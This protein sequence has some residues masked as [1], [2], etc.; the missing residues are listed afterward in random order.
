MRSKILVVYSTTNPHKSDEVEEAS[1]SISL[2]LPDGSSALIGDAFNFDIRDGRP[3]EPLERDL[4]EMVRHK[5]VSAYKNLL[6][7]CIAEHAG[8]IF[9]G[10]EDKSYPGG[11]TQPMWDAL[12]AKQF[13]EEIGGAGRRVIAR[14]VV[15]YC[16]GLNVRCFR[17]E[18]RG[19][20]AGSPRGQRQFY[21]DTVFVPEGES[22]TYAEI[23]TDV[24]RGIR[25]K[26]AISQSIRALRKFLEFRLTAGAPLLFP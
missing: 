6:V 18:T 7:P 21:W 4:E 3:S 16:D 23:C 5:V 26:L 11:L 15:G 25:A 24:G 8:L 20:L 13:I 10:H 2:T 12:G 14:A 22:Q 9:E 19:T 1:K 17:G